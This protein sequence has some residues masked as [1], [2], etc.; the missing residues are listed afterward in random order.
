MKSGTIIMIGM[1]LLIFVIPTIWIYLISIKNEKLFKKK[2]FNFAETSNCKI[3]ELDFWKKSVIGIDK[4][5]HRLFYI[6]TVNSEEYKKEIDLTEIQKCRV[7]NASRS[8]NNKDGNYTTVDKLELIFTYRDKTRPELALEFYNAI[9]DSLS[10]SGEVQLIEKWS[11]IV[12]SELG[13]K[14]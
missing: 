9:H 6:K 13:N 4:T 7:L 11:L 3:S 14:S 2:L 10:L 8:M 12:N 1:V 5:L